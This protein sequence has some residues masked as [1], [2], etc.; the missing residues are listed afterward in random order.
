MEKSSDS[1][2]NPFEHRST[3]NTSS[4]FGALAHMVKSML[5]AGL[6]AMPLAIK[7]CGLVLGTILALLITFLCGHGMHLIVKVSRIMCERTKQPMMNFEQTVLT[8]FETSSTE[9][10]QK[11][12]KW[13]KLFV[14]IA[15]IGCYYGICCVYIDIMA[16]SLKQ[17]LDEYLGD[18]NVRWYILMCALPLSVIGQTR[19]LKY[20]IPFS[21]LGNVLIISVAFIVLYKIFGGELNFA[22][23]NLGPHEFIS[24]PLFL[25]IVV[26]ALEPI[27]V[28]L[29]IENEMKTPADFTKTFGVINVSCVFVGLL[30]ASLGF[31]GYVRFG[32]EVLSSVTLNLAAGSGTS[33]TVQVMMIICVYISF[34]LNFYVATKAVWVYID[35]ETSPLLETI[36]RFWLV[37]ACVGL[38]LVIPNIGSFIGLVGSLFLASLGFIIPAVVNSVTLWPDELGKGN[39]VLVKDCFVAFFGVIAL[40][41]GTFSNL[42]EIIEMYTK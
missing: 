30:Y 9:K 38:A 16:S 26:F 12:A 41:S 34:G 6:F 20:L 17:E 1:K 37:M 14:N 32:D 33:I 28:T 25:S 19:A 31:F 23:R 35:D 24:V 5:G 29:V 3:E 15:L 42:A 21:T 7:H 36:I 18:L 8:A 10:I 13:M 2:Y 4:T 27:G 39:W 11:M 22:D 40:V